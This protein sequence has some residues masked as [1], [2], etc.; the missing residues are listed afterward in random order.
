MYFHGSTDLLQRIYGDILPHIPA[1]HLHLLLLPG[2][3]LQ[4]VSPVRS[5]E[6][7]LPFL[8]PGRSESY[9]VRLFQDFPE[10]AQESAFQVVTFRSAVPAP[11]LLP[12]PVT[13]NDLL[14]CTF[15]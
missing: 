7:Q 10:A 11:L 8:Y 2:C 5:P 9:P 12:Y 4:S 1:V 3:L 14:Q 6:K 15:L 13:E